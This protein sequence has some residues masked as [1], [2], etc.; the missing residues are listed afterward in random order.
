MTIRYMIIVGHHKEEIEVEHFLALVEHLK[1]M[2]N[3]FG[4]IDLLYRMG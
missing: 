3:R 2:V 4:P 1:M